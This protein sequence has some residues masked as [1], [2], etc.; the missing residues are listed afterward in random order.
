MYQSTNYKKMFEKLF[1]VKPKGKT[2]RK[3]D[4]F[5]MIKKSDNQNK[6]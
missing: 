3:N 4:L 1:L 5:D 2:Y 6:S